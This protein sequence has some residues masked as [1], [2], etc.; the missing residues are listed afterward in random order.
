M[1]PFSWLIVF[2]QSEHQ[3][4]A[5]IVFV[6]CWSKRRTNDQTIRIRKTGHH[7]TVLLGEWMCN[8]LTSCCVFFKT[9]A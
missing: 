3:Y 6:C 4:G 1:R 7:G 8:P 5:A 2:D 9:G